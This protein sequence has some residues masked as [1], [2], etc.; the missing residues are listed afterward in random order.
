MLEESPLRIPDKVIT[1][2]KKI[3][4]NEEI[5]FFVTLTKNIANKVRTIANITTLAVTSTN[6]VNSKQFFKVESRK[7]SK[8]IAFTIENITVASN[9]KTIELAI[10]PV[11]RAF[12]LGINNWLK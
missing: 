1:N 2:N 8:T 7:M 4:I 6:N 10:K 3:A 12:Q 5:D 11:R 9:D